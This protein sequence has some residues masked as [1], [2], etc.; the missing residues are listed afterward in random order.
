[1]SIF[2]FIGFRGGG[3]S[4]KKS[5]KDGSKGGGE[6]NVY[7][8]RPSY[9]IFDNLF[10]NIFFSIVSQVLFL[11]SSQLSTLSHLYNFSDF[12]VKLSKFYT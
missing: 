12:M 9:P 7:Q 1:M 2:G 8:H 10:I 6:K 4:I 11:K 3:G 5:R